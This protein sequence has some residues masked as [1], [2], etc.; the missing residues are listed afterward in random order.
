MVIILEIFWAVVCVGVGFWAIR[1]AYK[2][3]HS[4]NKIISNIWTYLEWFFGFILIT[5][6]FILV[7][8]GADNFYNVIEYILTMEV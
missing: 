3:Y 1:D 7:T 2:E 6:G 5:I 4:P 8:L